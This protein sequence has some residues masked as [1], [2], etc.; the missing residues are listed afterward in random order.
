[1]Q[2]SVLCWTI[3]GGSTARLCLT[4]LHLPSPQARRGAAAGPGARA[5]AGRRRVARAQQPTRNRTRRGKAVPT[6]IL[7]NLDERT[8]KTRPSSDQSITSL[9]DWRAAVSSYALGAEVQVRPPLG[10]PKTPA[11]ACDC[12]PAC[13]SS[14]PN[15]RVLHRHRPHP[16][17]AAATAALDLLS[18]QG[19]SGALWSIRWLAQSR[20]H[21]RFEPSSVGRGMHRDG[22]NAHAHLPSIHRAREQHPAATRKRL[23]AERVL[24]FVE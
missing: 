16:C 1:M 11:P 5:G 10:T 18:D 4:Y 6:S 15:A 14:N 13:T 22:A 23:S 17:S 24:T 2:K 7:T 19:S 12:N 9:T 8:R 20:T 3:G 21:R